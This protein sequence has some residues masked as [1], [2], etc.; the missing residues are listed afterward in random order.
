MLRPARKLTPTLAK[1][2]SHDVIVLH[3]RAALGSPANVDHIAVAPTGV[4]V[5][6]SER[7]TGTVEVEKK[8]FSEAKLKVRGR[9]R[10]KLAHGLTA[11][12]RLV[13][14]VVSRLAPGVPVH[15]VL[16]F[17]D[18]E[19][20]LIGTLSFAD[21]DLLPPRRLARRL[22]KPGRYPTIG[23]G[24]SRSALSVSFGRA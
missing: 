15:G 1:H 18:A 12:V 22:N 14:G 5:I 4:W 6:D 21:H 20:P 9:D 17:V 19:L 23:S 7:Y 8:L 2:C 10:T 24:P 3:D 11:Q 16:C 13:Q